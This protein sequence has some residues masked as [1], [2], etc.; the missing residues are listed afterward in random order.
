MNTTEAVVAV[1]SASSAQDLFGTDH[2]ARRYRE[3]ARALHP[4]LAAGADATAAFIRLARLWQDR[5]GTVIRTRIGEYRLNDRAFQGDLADLY[6]VG[7]GEFLKLPRS[8]VNNDLMEREALALRAMADLGDPRFLPYV[9]RVVESFLH[10]DATTGA[11]RRVTV[12][13]TVPGLRSLADVGAA[14]PGGVDPRDV[15]WMWRRLLVAIGFAH[16]AGLVHGAVLPTHVLIEPDE[17]GLVLVDWCYSATS[18]ERIP[19]LVPD[20]TDRYPAEVLKRQSPGP[21]TDIFMATRC[22]TDLM[23]PKA[24]GPLRSFAAGCALSSLDA[25][26]DD[27][28]RLLDELDGVLARLY[29]PRRFR[30]FRLDPVS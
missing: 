20:F 12:I 11:D 1:L 17:H 10:R 30:P 13:G 21:G 19:A 2:P 28:W 18:G 29:G 16:R 6:D 4:D 27:A 8:P 5:H 26:P 23:G 15:A 7:E 24:P 9:P 14:Y 22:M 3:L 25:R